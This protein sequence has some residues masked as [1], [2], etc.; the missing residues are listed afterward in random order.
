LREESGSATMIGS[1]RSREGQGQIISH[2][3][4]ERIVHLMSRISIIPLTTEARTNHVQPFDHPLLDLA[5]C[6]VAKLK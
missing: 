2:S 1:A 4:C 3:T 5:I 6:D